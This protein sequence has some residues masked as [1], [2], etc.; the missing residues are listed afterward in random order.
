MP[1]VRKSRVKLHINDQWKEKYEQAHNPDS[2]RYKGLLLTE[3]QIRDAMRNSRSNKEAA[4][5]LDVQYKTYKKYASMYIDTETGKSLFDIHYNR[6]GVGVR[7]G[8]G[9][10][11]LKKEIDE[12]LTENQKATEKRVAMLK[13][14]LIRDGRLGYECS[15]CSYAEKRL[16]DMKSPIL[17]SFANGNK[18]DWRIEN[19]KWMCYN[20]AFIY[21]LD[22]F[23]DAQMRRVESISSPA[24]QGMSV[25]KTD[26]FYDVDEIMKEQFKR[27]GLEDG[28]GD[29]IQEDELLDFKEDEDDGLGE[30]I[31][32][33]T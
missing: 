28:T 7:K 21:G 20:C 22:Y 25:D 10:K 23:S 17:L 8:Y 15:A 31:D 32:I 33:R 29:T 12:W 2:W 19:L 13:E 4:R 3:E 30:F 11:I 6:D 27:L 26:T 24:E 9:S 1:R 14:A 16:T 18:T 5:W